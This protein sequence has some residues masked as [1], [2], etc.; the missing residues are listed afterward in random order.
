MTRPFS[1]VVCIQ[2]SMYSCPRTDA[3]CSSSS[4]SSNTDK[5][6]QLGYMHSSVHVQL[7][8]HRRLLQQQQQQ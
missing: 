6:F 5:T 3:S 1:W 7:P 2:V 4:S 8:T